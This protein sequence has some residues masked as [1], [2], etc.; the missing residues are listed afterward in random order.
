MAEERPA[1]QLRKDHARMG[2]ELAGICILVNGLRPGDDDKKPALLRAAGYLEKR[3]LPHA[4]A[5]DCFIY[6]EVARLMGCHQ[7]T[8]TMSMDHRFIDNY[9]RAFRGEIDAAFGPNGK[10][11]DA[12]A[13]ARIMAA[14]HRLD[15]LLRAHFEKEE[16]I[17]LPLLETKM[18]AEELRRRVLDPMNALVASGVGRP[19]L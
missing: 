19:K 12:E 4:E 11:L 6:P 2:E 17:F 7:A 15:G 1:D 3:A 9:V 13:I 14:A 10:G 8:A 18:T 5:E 16:R